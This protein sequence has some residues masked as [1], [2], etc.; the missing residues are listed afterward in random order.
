[1]RHQV[2]STNGSCMVHTWASSRAGLIWVKSW[3]KLERDLRGYCCEMNLLRKAVSGVIFQKIWFDFLIFYVLDNDYILRTPH[4]KTYWPDNNLLCMIVDYLREVTPGNWNT[5]KARLPDN[6]PLWGKFCIANGGDNI[7]S[8]MAT[9]KKRTEWNMSFVRVC[10][11]LHASFL[12]R[13]S[14]LI[15]DLSL[16]WTYHI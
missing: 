2:A 1:M 14:Q 4:K 10:L 16:V 13:M 7:W 3:L 5:I 6:M 12:L 8:T 15:I 11:R 9:R